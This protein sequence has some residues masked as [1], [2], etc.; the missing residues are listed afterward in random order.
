MEGPCLCFPIT[1]LGAGGAGTQCFWQV[2]SSLVEKLCSPCGAWVPAGGSNLADQDNP[3]LLSVS[4]NV[5]MR[6][7]ESLLRASRK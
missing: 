1:L 5:G 7:E 3:I 4:N 2:W 6:H